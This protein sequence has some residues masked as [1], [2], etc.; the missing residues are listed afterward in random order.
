[1]SDHW[2]AESGAGTQSGL[3][4]ANRMAFSSLYL[5]MVYG[6]IGDGDTVY[7]VRN[8]DDSPIEIYLVQA[9]EVAPSASG[10]STNPLTITGCNHLGVVDGKRTKIKIITGS[11]SYVFRVGLTCDYVRFQHL[12]FDCNDLCGIPITQVG[13]ATAGEYPTAYNIHAT[14]GERCVSFRG[15][16]AKI[17]NCYAKDMTDYGFVLTGNGSQIISNCVAID[18]TDDSGNSNF[19]ISETAYM[20][21]CYSE[22]GAGFGVRV[23]G[24]NASVVSCTINGAGVDGIQSEHHGF[25]AINNII[26]NNTV[27]GLDDNGADDLNI[28]DYNLYYNNTSGNRVDIGKGFHDIDDEDPLFSNITAYD[29]SVGPKSPAWRAGANNDTIGAPLRAKHKSPIARYI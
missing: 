16:G 8:E 10:T 17:H 22:G 23:A 11:I 24:D 25:T 3:S 18:A 27:Y 26:S 29:Y 5:P 21:N 2:V 13:G 9:V 4:F 14:N 28:S 12:E 15:K 7:I 6:F 1:M 19:Y 20:V